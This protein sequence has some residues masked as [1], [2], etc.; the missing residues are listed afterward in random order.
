MHQIKIEKFQGPFSLLLDLIEQNKLDIT[1]VSLFEIADQYL[2]KI[3]AER[4]HIKGNEL[5]DFLL[6]AAKLLFIKSRLL[7]PDLTAL[8]A[9]EDSLEAQLK[10]Y[11]AYRDASRNIKNIIN[12]QN[13]TQP[14][15]PFKLSTQVEFSPP[16][17][18]NSDTLCKQ[19]RRI[20]NELEKT[21]IR[22]PKATLRKTISLAERIN[23]LKSLLSGAAQFGFKEFVTR[24]KN[25]SEIV[26]S[27]L[28]LL[29]L[30]K[31]RHISASQEE[32]SDIFITKY[33]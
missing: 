17:K 10:M 6:I 22:L 23:D 31:Q 2:A 5:A 30:I 16:E 18:L 9:D 19:F 20:V 14:R 11:K 8:P 33:I 26:V 28:A 12:E 27:F 25:K 29:E 15:Q 21:I 32:G 3:E 13:F 24:A 1:E 4:A 7:L